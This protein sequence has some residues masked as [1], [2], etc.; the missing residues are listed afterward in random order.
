M[1]SN[2]FKWSVKDRR[3]FDEFCVF[4][5]KKEKEKEEKIKL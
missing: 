2:Y 5:G 3:I 1:L 4:W